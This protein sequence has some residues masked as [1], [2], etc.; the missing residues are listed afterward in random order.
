MEY[1]VWKF[2]CQS[3]EVVEGLLFMLEKCAIGN[4]RKSDIIAEM[5]RGT[6]LEDIQRA[7]SSLVYVGRFFE[8]FCNKYNLYSRYGSES[9][10]EGD[11]NEGK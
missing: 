2:V 9:A 10:F 6:T 8:L 11:E 5:K 1:A 3:K 7:V 4:P